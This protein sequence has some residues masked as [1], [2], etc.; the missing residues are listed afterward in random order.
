[1]HDCS[2]NVQTIG[3]PMLTQHHSLEY[4]SLQTILVILAM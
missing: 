3:G 1:M 4:F 2:L